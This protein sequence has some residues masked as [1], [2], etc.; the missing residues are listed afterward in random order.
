MGGGGLFLNEDTEPPL[1]ASEGTVLALHTSLLSVHKF[2][3]VNEL[4]QKT[5]L[6]QQNQQFCEGNFGRCVYNTLTKVE[7]NLNKQEEFGA[8]E[9]VEAASE[10]YYF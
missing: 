6:P 9:T 8:L 3:N 7:K 5:L 1:P 10:L 4:Q 2:T